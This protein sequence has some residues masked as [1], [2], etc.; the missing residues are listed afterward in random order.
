MNM[1]RINGGSK[2]Q[3]KG[4]LVVL[5][6]YETCIRKLKVNVVPNSAYIH[7][8]NTK[9]YDQACKHWLKLYKSEQDK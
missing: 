1:I 4:L 7:V 5:K 6:I 8:T 3:I 2:D 9:V